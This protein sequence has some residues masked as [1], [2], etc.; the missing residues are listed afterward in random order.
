MTTIDR[1]AI[2]STP[3]VVRAPPKSDTRGSTLR[4]DCSV[5][6]Q[7]LAMSRARRLVSFTLNTTA[8]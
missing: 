5:S 2:F 8:K 7:S 1:L 6:T 3:R 4:R